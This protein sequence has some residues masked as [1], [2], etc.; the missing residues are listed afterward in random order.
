LVLA[1]SL[2]AIGATN[3]AW[4]EVAEADVRFAGLILAFGKDAK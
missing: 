1:V 3:A 2:T 4:A